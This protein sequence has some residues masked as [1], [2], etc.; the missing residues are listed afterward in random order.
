MLEVPWNYAGIMSY[1]FQPLPISNAENYA[2]IIDAG[3]I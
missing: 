2:D 3:L 1:A